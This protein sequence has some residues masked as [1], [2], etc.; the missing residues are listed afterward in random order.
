MNNPKITIE[1]V[2]SLEING[3]SQIR[4]QFEEV[5]SPLLAREM[6]LAVTAHLLQ[7]EIAAAKALL[8][9]QMQNDLKLMTNERGA[10]RLPRIRHN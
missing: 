9:A 7:T 6:L 8:D 3:Q 5:N 10:V 4:W 1:V 2:R